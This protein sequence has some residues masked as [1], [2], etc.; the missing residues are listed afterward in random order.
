ME[1]IEDYIIRDMGEL[2][3]HYLM[4]IDAKY[5]EIP[6]GTQEWQFIAAYFSEWSISVLVVEGEPVGYFVWEV[7]EHDSSIRVH[8]FVSPPNKLMMDLLGFEIELEAEELLMENIAFM[9]P[10]YR[11][12]GVGDPYDCSQWLLSKGYKC[13]EVERDMMTAYGQD[14]DC[15]IFRK[16][17]NYNE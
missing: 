6:W 8:R 13:D 14:Y 4:A 12:Q 3:V 5:S 10:E 7:Y 2:D 1:S 17:V 9:V 16:K 15:F 11:S